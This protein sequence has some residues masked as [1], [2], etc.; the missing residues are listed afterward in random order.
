MIYLWI[1]FINDE[2]DEELMKIYNKI[3]EEIN[4]ET[5][6]NKNKI[7]QKDKK[8]DNYI[9]KM[10]KNLEK[11]NFSLDYTENESIGKS[12][13]IEENALKED[14]NSNFYIL[15]FE[16]NDKKQLK[17]KKKF[18]KWDNNSCR[19]DSLIFLFVYGIIPYISNDEEG[20]IFS[21]RR[22]IK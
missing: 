12:L 8:K 11:D 6:L 21:F 2:E 18:L 15:N 17:I 16:T 1:D 3:I 13:D 14:I 22:K 4:N 5:E 19:F 9:D 20:E 7:E 10:T